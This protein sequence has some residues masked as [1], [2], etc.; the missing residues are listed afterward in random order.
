M[1][2][3]E[4]TYRSVLSAESRAN[5]SISAPAERASR[6]P[7]GRWC[8]ERSLSNTSTV[9]INTSK[10]NKIN[11]KKKQPGKKRVTQSG[12]THG[13][14]T[15]PKQNRCQSACRLFLSHRNSRPPALSS[16][17]FRAPSRRVV[18]GVE[19]DERGSLDASYQLSLST[20]Q[21]IVLYRI[22]QCT[23]SWWRIYLSICSVR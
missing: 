9:I 21:R 6:S 5:I 23:F 11:N 20:K 7:Y 22:V 10:K 4:R 16:S 2:A 15:T 13:R 8:A 19:L 12:C 14:E 1:G 17:S 3:T 18:V